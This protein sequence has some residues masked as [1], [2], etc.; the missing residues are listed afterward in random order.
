MGVAGLPPPEVIDS[1]IFDAGGVL[2]L[3]D[4]TPVRETIASLG[5]DTSHENWARSFSVSIMAV[6]TMETLDWAAV[7]RTFVSGL[8]VPEEHMGPTLSAVEE[9]VFSRP[10]APIKG[11]ADVLRALGDAGYTL[12]VVSNAGGTIAEEL[13][14]HG[15]CSVTNESCPRVGA[16]I[17]SHLVGVEKPDP[18]IFHLAL[19]ALGVQPEAA[20]Y[21]GDTVRFDVRGAEAAGL[22][23]LHLDPY[24]L[25]DGA[26]AHVTELSEITDW[27][28][29]TTPKPDNQTPR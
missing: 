3:P 9:L 6:D 4:A 12:G 25:C 22:F 5:C 21:V 8:G 1:V 10:W 13:E 17:D 27:L 15:I 20:V 19:D 2:L 7:R 18:R 23:P 14:G 29:P 24:R 26:H 16:I 11:A 28:L